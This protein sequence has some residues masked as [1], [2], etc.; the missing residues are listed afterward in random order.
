MLTI[1]A[2]LLVTLFV[3]A[4]PLLPT[5][6]VQREASDPPSV[7]ILVLGDIGRSPRMQYHAQ[8]FLK[9]KAEVQLIG[10]LG[11]KERIPNSRMANTP[12]I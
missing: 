1:V 5:R 12:R 10:Y 7:Q 2:V 3:L 6:Y 9:H 4:L 11:E 8:S